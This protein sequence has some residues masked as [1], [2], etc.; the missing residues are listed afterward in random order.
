MS[1]RIF[2]TGDKHGSFVP[3]FGLHEKGEMRETDVFIIAG[4]AGY[5][6]D[7]DYIYKVETLQQ[8]FP[9]TVAFID[10]NHENHMLLDSMEVVE[11]NGGRVHQVG[12]RV[13]HLMRGELYSIYGCNIFTFG[14]ARS[15]DI[16]RRTDGESWW[17]EEEPSLEEIDYGRNMLMEKA[18]E[19]DY[20]IT[21]E[22]PLF[23]RDHISR[24]KEIDFDYHLPE[25]LDDWYKTVSEGKR[26]KKWYFGH[27]HEDRQI[28]PKLRAIHN[29][30]LIIGE[31][32]PIKWA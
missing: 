8:L 15:S 17:R 19:I 21:H 27:M 29:D 30:I 6:W 32:E 28:T 10:G 16:D 7:E 22:T 9:G 5:V 23:A 31:D 14:G 12:E 26:F 2:I 13:C 24:S 4:D 20:V 3:F 25:I 18:D 1:G 11:W